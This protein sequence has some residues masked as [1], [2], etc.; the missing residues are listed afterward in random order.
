MAADFSKLKRPV[1]PIPEK[2]HDA[3]VQNHVMEAYQSR[4]AYQQNDYIGWIMRA[5]R[6]DTYQKRLNQMLEELKDG[7][8]YMNMPYGPKK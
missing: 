5:K 7:V 1:Y 3:L 4:P 6:E 8:L 2:I